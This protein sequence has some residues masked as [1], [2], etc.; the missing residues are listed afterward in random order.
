MGSKV[1]QTNQY[2]G[3]N[4]GGQRVLRQAITLL[5]TELDGL[6]YVEQLYAHSEHADIQCAASTS[7][8]LR[9]I[10]EQITT[11]TPFLEGEDQSLG[12]LLQQLARTGQ[13]PS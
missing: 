1:I 2:F 11:L 3:Q 9:I 8:Q 7:R 10:R 12:T 5:H 13:R 4:S 6:E